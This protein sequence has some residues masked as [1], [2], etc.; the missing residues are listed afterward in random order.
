MIYEKNYP[1]HDLEPVAV[2]FSLI[3]WRHY[4]YGVRVDVFTVHKNLWYVLTQKELN[5]GERRSLEF[6]KD[7]DM[8]VLYHLDRDNVVVDAI[9]RVS[10]GSVPHVDE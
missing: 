4:L 6:L 2:V 10:M 3:I 5:I 9:N 1:T 8:T 7:Y